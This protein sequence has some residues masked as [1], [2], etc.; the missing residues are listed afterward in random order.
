MKRPFFAQWEQTKV[1]YGELETLR[2]WVEAKSKLPGTDVAAT[3]E[4]RVAW[5]LSFYP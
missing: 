2:M 3:G 1:Y 5:G 4:G